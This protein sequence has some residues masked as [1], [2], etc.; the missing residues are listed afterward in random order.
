MVDEKST[1]FSLSMTPSEPSSRSE[2]PVLSTHR[3][4]GSASDGTPG[5]QHGDAYD[6]VLPW[7]RARI[8][9]KLVES[10]EVESN[11]IA[12]LQVCQKNCVI[13]FSKVLIF[14]CKSKIRAPWL[15]AYFVYT[16]SLGTHTF[17]MIIL[18][19]FFF[20]GYGE[21]GRG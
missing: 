18:P 21:L 14:L 5:L 10:I 7:W 19:A 3:N 15:D 20:F 6:R 12:M 2:S 13:L 8:R 11:I 9:R 16:S 1:H 4:N 17:F